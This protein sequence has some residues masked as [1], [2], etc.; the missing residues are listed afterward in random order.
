ME[1]NKLMV[2]SDENKMIIKAV[3]GSAGADTIDKINELDTIIDKL[4]NIDGHIDQ[5]VRREASRYIEQWD[6]LVMRRVTDKTNRLGDLRRALGFD[7][8][9]DNIFY[10]SED[11]TLDGGNVIVDVLKT[12]SEQLAAKYTEALDKVEEIKNYDIEKRPVSPFIDEDTMLPSDIAMANLQYKMDLN[13][14]NHEISKM[15]ADV[16]RI[17]YDIRKSVT[18][19]SRFKDFI[20]QLDA[21]IKYFND[22][23][24]LVSEKGALA[25]MNILIPNADVRNILKELSAFQREL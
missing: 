12:V 17:V 8:A 1:N 7:N 13:K 15:K 25:K 3:C 19:N 11:A 16:K 9:N 23:E 21:Q 14:H 18:K 10:I 4:G 22:A 20:K 24:S 6:N 5:D 2:I